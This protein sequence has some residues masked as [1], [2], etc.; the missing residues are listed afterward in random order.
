MSAVDPYTMTDRLDDGYVMP[1]ES[2]VLAGVLL[3]RLDPREEG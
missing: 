3:P 1:R 2:R